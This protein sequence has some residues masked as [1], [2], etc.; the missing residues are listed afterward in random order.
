MLRHKLAPGF[1]DSWMNDGIDA[2]T[3][4]FALAKICCNYRFHQLSLRIINLYSQ[5]GTQFFL[6]C[7]VGAH[8][9]F[10]RIIS[11][12]DGGSQLS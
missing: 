12:E 1:F 8:D 5:Q 4:G 9:V 2:Q 10:R 11:I 6:Y 7:R 3:V